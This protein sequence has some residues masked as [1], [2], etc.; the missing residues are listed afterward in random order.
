MSTTRI[1]SD[2][3]DNYRSS[4]TGQQNRQLFSTRRDLPVDIVLRP[5]SRC[6]VKAIPI[7]ASRL[8][9]VVMDDLCERCYWVKL[10]LNHHLPFQMFPSIVSR[11]C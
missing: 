7:S 8:G 10:H 1:V 5:R 2:R 6:S 4:A 11:F 3:P 9:E